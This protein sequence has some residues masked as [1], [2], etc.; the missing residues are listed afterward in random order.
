ME[1]DRP[2]KRLKILEKELGDDYGDFRLVSILSAAYAQAH[3][4][5]IVGLALKIGGGSPKNN[6][7]SSSNNNALSAICL[8]Y[9]MRPMTIFQE[10]AMR[11]NCWN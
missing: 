8:I 6:N 9:R 4:I 7:T 1:Q 3:G 2:E 10:L 11:L 5:D